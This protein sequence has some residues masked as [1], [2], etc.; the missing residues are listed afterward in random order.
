MPGL[1]AYPRAPG[2]PAKHDRSRGLASLAKTFGM[3][4][5]KRRPSGRFALAG[6]A[7]LAVAGCVAPRGEAPAV[8]SEAPR[9]IPAAGLEGVIGTTAR[10]LHAQFGAAD[11]DLHEGNAHK[12]QYIAPACVLDLY[13]YP[14]RAGAEP[15][16][17]HVDA[18]LPDGREMDRASCV[19]ALSAREASR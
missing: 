11:L 10:A 17:T 14:P 16:V 5:A 19:A 12:L 4:R 1:L 13:L 2:E 15:V 3:I 18:R 9:L 7:A 8:R 6:A